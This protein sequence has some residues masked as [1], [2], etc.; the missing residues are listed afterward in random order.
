MTDH[1]APPPLDALLA[2]REWVR[3]LARSLA[4]DDA[5]AEDLTQD[6]MLTAIER[7]PRH[8][9]APAGWLRRVLVRRS[10]D[11]ARGERRRAAREGSL[12]RSDAAPA[13]DE[14]VAVAE[15]HRRVVE[16]VM[17]LDEPY[18]T[19]VLLRFFEDLPPREVAARMGVPVDTVRARVRRAV[20]RLR[21][22][23]DE[24]HDGRRAL[25]LAPLLRSA[26]ASTTAPAP[27]ASPI[28]VGKL[29][30]AAAALSAVALTAF[31]LATSDRAA[32][33]AAPPPEVAARGAVPAP[34]P[35]PRVRARDDASTGGEE[36]DGNAAAPPPDGADGAE[37]AAPAAAPDAPHEFVVL[38]M[39]ASRAPVEGLRV[40]IDPAKMD[41]EPEAVSDA[42]GRAVF[43]VIGDVR[44]AEFEDGSADGRAWRAN[45]RWVRVAP[46]ATSV[47]LVVEPAAWIKGHA[48]H[49][50]GLDFEFAEVV[51][52]DHGR[53]VATAY[54][55]RDGDFAIAVPSAGVF[56]LVLTGGSHERIPS[57]DS[58]SPTGRMRQVMDRWGMDGGELPA[59]APGT[60]GLSLR[61][62]KP[63]GS[64]TLRVRVR[65]A[66]GRAVA[67]V[68]IF[69]DVDPTVAA[70]GPP[71]TGADG[72]CSIAN[73]PSRRVGVGVAWFS[74]KERPKWELEGWATPR[75]MLLVRPSDGETEIVLPAGRAIQGRVEF[76]K[77]IV[78]RRV[79]LDLVEAGF[80]VAQAQTDDAGHFLLVVPS[81]SPGPFDLRV[82]T[83]EADASGRLF[84]LHADP[85]APGA[86]EVVLKLVRS[87]REGN[88]VPD[89]P[90]AAP[91]QPS[92]APP[93]FAPK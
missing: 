17:E 24:G 88:P 76:P 8:G 27:S 48:S 3:H 79:R 44:S 83:T 93:K 28:P 12:A 63:D 2:R 23:L 57:G 22:R 37:P 68:P 45:R 39:D 18:R 9:D 50:N 80:Y 26:D 38:A 92:A 66:D 46:G 21:D 13:V 81:T 84:G 75:E 59:V 77:E 82:C 52:V 91:P 20:E 67:G 14:V 56:D 87:D 55:T 89:E 42:K 11:V 74:L 86:S 34:A 85:F 78:P 69:T 47:E 73:L 19:T 58:N 49:A 32:P 31:L 40:R 61:A 71:T 7:P 4:R 70:A 51:A 72:R 41:K 35:K 10:M 53:R 25:W 16:A 1:T 54:A 36:P 29:L 62:C 30:L 33:G 43:E 6:T 90:P 15:S 60:E 64:G 65:T 5:A